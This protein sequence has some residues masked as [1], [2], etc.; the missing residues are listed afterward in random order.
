LD[1]LKLIGTYGHDLFSSLS[2]RVSGGFVRTRLQPDIS[3][4]ALPASAGN[5]VIV[6]GIDFD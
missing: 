1:E 6:G 4:S 3:L 2:A 5:L